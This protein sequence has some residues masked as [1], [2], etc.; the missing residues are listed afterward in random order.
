MTA[1]NAANANTGSASQTR[2]A[3]S[4]WEDVLEIV[5]APEWTAQ[6]LLYSRRRFR[7]AS[8]LDT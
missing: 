2:M 4:S 8:V 7:L 6:L 3:P 1:W 5:S